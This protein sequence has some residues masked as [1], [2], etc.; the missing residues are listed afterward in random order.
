MS[1]ES[2]AI[3]TSYASIFLPRYSGVRPTIRPAMNTA[4]TTKTSIPYKPGANTAEDDFAE[5]NIE[6]RHEAA[7]RGERI[8]HR[9][10]RTA[11]GIRCDRGEERGIENAE[12]DFLP[13]HVAAGNAETLVNRITIRLRPPAQQHSANEKGQHRGPDGPAV[14]LILHH[15]AEVVSQPAADRENRQH[16]E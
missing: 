15:S 14:F 5:L 11:G 16:L 9:I 7:E 13:L 2:I 3:F 4:S 10:D 1:N 8:V 12:P 6:Q